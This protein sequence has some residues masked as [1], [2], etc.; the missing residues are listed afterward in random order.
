MCTN[1][2][3]RQ[4]AESRSLSYLTLES[5]PQIDDKGLEN[6]ESMSGLTKLRLGG[7]NVTQVGIAKLKMALP[8][9]EIIHLLNGQS[10]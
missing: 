7:T 5:N 8:M 1:A 10:E 6:L 4:I 3:L 2:G 9:C